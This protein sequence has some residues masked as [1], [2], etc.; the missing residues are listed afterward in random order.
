VDLIGRSLA[1]MP[2]LTSMDSSPVPNPAWVDNP[3]PAVYVSMVDA[4]KAIVNSLL[5]RGAAFIVATARH[6]SGMVARWV[7]LNPDM[8]E[9]TMDEFGMPTYFIRGVGIVPRSEILHIRYQV[10][11]GIPFGVGPL[12][13]AWRNT[14]GADALERWGTELAIGN[15]IPTA[16][17]QSQTKLT[18]EQARA[19]KQSWA[20]AAMTRGTLPVVLSGGLTYTPLNLKPAEVGLLDLRAFDEARIASCFG[21]PLWLVGLPMQDGL[22]YATV[23]GTFDYFWR[24]TLRPLSV[25]IMQ[26]LTQ[27]CLPVGV[28]V[29]HDADHFIRPALPER[30]QAY[31]ILVDSGIVTVDEIRVWENMHPMG[32]QTALIMA[33][34]TNGEI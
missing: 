11:P 9:I 18:G 7:V 13:A 19:L 23:V 17:L 2:I 8:V 28:A 20:E 16:I 1:S 31:K 24:A 29:R 6:P 22:T 12:E 3:E 5:M 21:V 33:Q 14:V 32:D 25:D 27:F 15:G 30:A 26:A 34:Q 4:M 10:W